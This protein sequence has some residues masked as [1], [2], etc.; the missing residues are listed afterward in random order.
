VKVLES[1]DALERS[2]ASLRGRMSPEAKAA[3]VASKRD[4]ALA[5]LSAP[6]IL[7]SFNILPQA[8]RERIES[9]LSEQYDTQLRTDGKA[10]EAE[11]AAITSGLSAVTDAASALPDPFI[12]EDG[13]GA[14]DTTHAMR[15]VALLLERDH[16]ERRLTGKT[17]AQVVDLYITADD[18]RD[19]VL[20]HTIE[21]QVRRGWP[22]IA[23]HV[24]ETPDLVNVKRLTAAIGKARQARLERDQ[25]DVV[26]AAE[27]FTTITKAVGT[28]E[29]LR[30]LRKG[31]GVKGSA[32]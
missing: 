32:R 16:I 26:K 6:G 28:T 14:G 27:K 7:E 23:L 11:I 5:Q 21:D 10:I 29:L 24:P 15:R 1:V 19:H 3:V 2:I 18:R 12:A 17:V 20:R 8:A 30:L 9:E 31:Y 25:P 13:T 22:D 4:A